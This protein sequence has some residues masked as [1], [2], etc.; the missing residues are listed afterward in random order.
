MQ[1]PDEEHLLSVEALS[2]ARELLMGRSIQTNQGEVISGHSISYGK[3]YID[4]YPEYIHDRGGHR[5]KVDGIMRILQEIGF[6]PFPGA[7]VVVVGCGQG[8]HDEFLVRDYGLKVA[9]VDISE[10]ALEI[11][12]EKATASGLNIQYT[13]ADA[14]LGLPFKQNSKRAV[15]CI[16][17]SWGMDPQDERNKNTFAYIFAILEAE[18]V[19]VLDYVNGQKWLNIEGTKYRETKELSYGVTRIVEGEYYP[20]QATQITKVTLERSGQKPQFYYEHVK[21]YPIKEVITMLE[22][23]GFI[24]QKICGDFGGHAFNPLTS[25]QMIIIATKC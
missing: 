15:F 1:L 6:M 4:A 7:E 2:F 10:E 24:I 12:R 19:F 13:Y 11:A 16:G 18:G 9:G 20:D 14:T 8:T 5:L 25:D 3:T 22:A 17:T 21:Y 23:A